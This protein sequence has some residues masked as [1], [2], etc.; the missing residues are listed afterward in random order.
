MKNILLCLLSVLFFSGSLAQKTRDVVF[1][2]NGS[3]IRGDITE[4]NDSVIKIMTCCENVF[5]YKI[6]E[7]KEIRAEKVRSSPAAVRKRGYINLT[8]VGVLIGSSDDEKSAP[9][10]VIMEHNYRFNKNI[11]LGGFMGFEQL[12]ENLLPLGI[13][14]KVLFPVGRSD[15]FMTCLGGYSLS[16]EKP[17]ETGMKKATG[18]VLAGTELGLLIPVS[19]GSAIV[20]ALGYRYNELNYK[21]EDWYVGNINRNITYNRFVLR[22]GISIF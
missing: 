1:L 4:Q 20:F 12:N 8:S 14:L 9:V 22:C 18:G 13:N 21:L 2:H 15:L 3:I 10:S 19:Q 16:L 6:A 7:I 17:A 5:V 11:A